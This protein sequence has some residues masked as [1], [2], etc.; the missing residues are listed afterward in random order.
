ME[1]DPWV[2][3]QVLDPNLSVTGFHGQ[4]VVHTT[5][6][7]ALL[8]QAIEHGGV[9]HSP[10]TAYIMRSISRVWDTFTWRLFLTDSLS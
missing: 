6:V 5:R 2:V 4:A 8:Q 10:F 7:E 1:M 9:C 3:A